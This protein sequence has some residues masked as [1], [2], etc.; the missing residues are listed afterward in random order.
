MRPTVLILL[1]SFF[2]Q[3]LTFGQQYTPP[4]FTKQEIESDLQFVKEKL[5]NMHPKFLNEIYS[6]NWEIKYD[7]L[8][9]NLP[10][11]ISYNKIFVAMSGLMAEVE[12]SHT[13]FYFPFEERGKYM[14]N[15]GGGVTMPFTIRVK[16]NKLFIDEYFGENRSCQIQGSELLSINSINSEKLLNDVRTLVGVKNRESGDKS[17]E[18]LFGMCYWMLYG[19]TSEYNLQIAGTDSLVKINSVNNDQYFE[20][21]NIYYPQKKHKVYELNFSDANE[22]AFLKIESFNGD[23]KFDSFLMNAFNT[24]KRNKCKYLIIDVRDNPGGR[25]RGVDSLLNYL[26]EKSY[27]QYSSIGIRVSEEIKSN[28]KE[29]NPE[30]FNLIKD[31]PNDTLFYLNDSL[32]VHEPHCKVSYFMGD[33]YVL[34]NERTNSAAATFVG[35]VKEKKIGKIIGCKPTGENIRYYGDFLSFTLPNSKMKIIVSPK[36]FIQYGGADLNNGVVPDI[37]LNDKEFSI[38]DIICD[39]D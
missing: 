35:V 23:E 2:S 12:D 25:S 1:L 8:C 9:N 14:L 36:E 32:L 28:Y 22:F 20:L 4:F 27:S 34:V 33:I 3:H 39:E 24:I 21:K 31:L 37:L 16:N 7:S 13:G 29:R 6:K 17:V 11:S 19:E 5:F 10:D 15:G 30:T 18:M 38:S 26:T